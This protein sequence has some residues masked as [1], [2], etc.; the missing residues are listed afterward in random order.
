MPFASSPDSKQKRWAKSF[1]SEEEVSRHGET[2]RQ[3]KIQKEGEEELLSTRAVSGSFDSPA[4]KAR[5]GPRPAPKSATLG[6]LALLL[7]FLGVLY[8]LVTF[9]PEAKRLWSVYLFEARERA[10][11]Y[12]AWR[13]GR[14]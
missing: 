8:V 9:G 5:P 12:K 13:E 3:R 6:D 1:V 14:L 7:S 11:E 4:E 10:K 2:L